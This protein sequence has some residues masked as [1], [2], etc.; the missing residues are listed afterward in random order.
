MQD[1]QPTPWFKQFW[2][3]F[4]IALPSLMIVACMYLIALSFYNADELVNDDYYKEGLAIN[5]QLEKDHRARELD[6][7]AT[8]TLAA[9]RKKLRLDLQG[10]FQHYPQMLQVEFE[11]PVSASQDTNLTL[12]YRDDQY[13]HGSL[14]APIDGRWYISLQ[15]T[16][17]S[18]EDFRLTGELDLKITPSIVLIPKS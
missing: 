9:D 18:G 16:L 14:D 8:L 4:I 17:A 2:P 5:R 10:G 3:W 11:H 12:T 6:A 7:R 15:G 13:Y 1:V